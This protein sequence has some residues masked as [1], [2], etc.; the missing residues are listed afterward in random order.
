MTTQVEFF[1]GHFRRDIES[2]EKIGFSRWQLR[3]R[4]KV[5]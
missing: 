2:S 5:S 3:Y 4:M 1:R